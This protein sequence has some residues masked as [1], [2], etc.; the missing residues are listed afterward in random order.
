MLKNRPFDLTKEPP[1][2]IY[3]QNKMRLFLLCDRCSNAAVLI[4]G[5]LILSPIL[6]SS[7]Y[8]AYAAFAVLLIIISQL[9]IGWTELA[10]RHGQLAQELGEAIRD[11]RAKDKATG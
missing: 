2:V 1:G 3:H 11:T 4:T 7:Q 8:K 5:V 10:S 6:S 9:V